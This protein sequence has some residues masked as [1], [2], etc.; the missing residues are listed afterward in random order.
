[1]QGTGSIPGIQDLRSTFAL[2]LVLIRP[3]LGGGFINQGFTSVCERKTNGRSFRS[4]RRD[5]GE[6]GD[7]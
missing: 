4:D 3:I 7:G 1:M 5:G 6:V 2:R